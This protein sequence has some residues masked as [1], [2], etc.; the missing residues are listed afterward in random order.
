VVTATVWNEKSAPNPRVLF[1]FN[2][3]LNAYEM[4]YLQRCGG[5][6]N[7][8]YAIVSLLNSQGRNWK[9]LRERAKESGECIIALTVRVKGQRV[10]V[11][12]CLKH[13][14]MELMGWSNVICAIDDKPHEWYSTPEKKCGK[15]M[16]L[17]PMKKSVFKIPIARLEEKLQKQPELNPQPSPE[18][19]L[20]FTS[21][22][23]K[24][25]HEGHVVTA[26]VWNEK[27]A[28]NPR[29]LFDFN[30]VLNAYEMSYL[31]R[32]GGI[33]NLPYAI[34]SLLNSQGRNWKVLRERAKE[35]GECIIALTVRVKG[36]RVKV[37]TCL[38]HRAMEL[39]GWS[40]VICAIDD[41]PHEWYSTPEKKCGK[42]MK[43][44]PMKKSVFKIPIRRRIQSRQ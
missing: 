15:K 17:D 9:V 31:Q 14:A 39:M 21:R 8:P 5:I 27:S 35:S 28:P 7:L 41:K 29:V 22:E 34:V 24:Y 25:E 37:E 36:Q 10:K 43:L 4:S 30:N 23:F 33:E 1:D 42:K 13:R 12:T 40:N 20:R 11:E 44:D 38:K 2:N 16:K 26:T 6:E 18:P 19:Q 3:V 32:C